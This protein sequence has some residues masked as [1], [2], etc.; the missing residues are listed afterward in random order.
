MPFR[1][2]G[3][4]AFGYLS[5]AYSVG[6]GSLTL[7]AGQGARFPSMA[8]GDFFYALL[9]DESYADLDDNWQMVKV[10][11]RSSDILTI[12][13]AQEGTTDKAFPRSVGQPQ[14]CRVT[15]IL[16]AR[17]LRMWASGGG[18][19]IQA[20]APSLDLDSPEPVILTPIANITVSL[21][22]T[23]V[24]IGKKFY[25][26]NLATAFT[27]TIK[28]SD[29]VTVCILPPASSIVL[30]CIQD[31]PT[32][33]TDWAVPATF[34][35]SGFIFGTQGTAT[36]SGGGLIR[37]AN[38]ASLMQTTTVTLG[39]VA[40]GVL[41][42]VAMPANT[43]GSKGRLLLF[44]AFG[45]KTGANAAFSL[46]WRIGGTAIGT[47]VN[48]TL[49]TAMNWRMFLLI[50]YVAAGSQKYGHAALPSTDA[51]GSTTLCGTGTLTKD[52]TTALAVDINCT[53]KSAADVVTGEILAPTL[54]G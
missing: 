38:G 43:L 51:T 44:E 26:V 30:M 46:Q 22:T 9:V 29:G 39:A 16:S 53:T 37:D 18:A 19:L 33:S 34:F 6:Q 8:A 11:A 21:P 25:F 35:P 52:E 4:R 17:Q 50:A 36:H 47:A 20:A 41:Q 15:G 40:S 27:V 2:P 7:G 31:T 3:N 49:L 28:S 32:D 10:T 48:Y 23:G 12:T 13:A 1:P 14:Q 24:W 5:A 42:S 45:T 54:F